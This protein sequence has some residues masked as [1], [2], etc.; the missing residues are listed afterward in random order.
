MSDNIKGKKILFI[1]TNFYD[2]E[3]YIISQFESKGAEVFYFSSVVNTLKKRILLRLKLRERYILYLENYISKKIDDLPLDIDF[4]FVIKA[5]N[6]KE[7]HFMQL[8]AKYPK[9]PKVLYLWDSIN[10]LDNTDLLLSQFDSIL[11]FDREDVL[12]YNFIFRPLFY[13]EE[14]STFSGEIDYD[15]SFVGGN[16]SIRYDLIKEIR[17]VLDQNKVKYKFCLVV[18]KFDYLLGLLSGKYRIKDRDLFVTHKVS[19]EEYMS[20]GR[21]SNV[22][23]DISNPFQTGLTIRTIE[24]IGLK[25]KL[26]TTNKDICNYNF[27]V[28]FY[29]VIDSNK[30][31]LNISFLKD[32]FDDDLDTSKYSCESFIQDIVNSFY[33][34]KG[35]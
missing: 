7:S 1:G 3:N 27:P 11:S 16:H 9:V 20:I 29:E 4:I 33:S 22:I 17:C 14:D 5:E 35:S 21:R 18:G 26:L 32:S 25:K 10:N 24:T 13:R 8:K 31:I 30:P 2:Y 28:S 15:I 19:Y 34:I 23:L 6:L 12:R